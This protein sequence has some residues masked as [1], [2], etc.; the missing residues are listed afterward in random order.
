MIAFGFTFFRT[1]LRLYFIATVIAG[2]L[3]AQTLQLDPT[4]DGDGKL[5]VDFGV[6]GLR[7]SFASQLF[8]QPSGRIVVYGTHVMGGQS[9]TQGNAACGLTSGG[10]LDSGFGSGGRAV[11]LN[12][13]LLRR[14]E[15]LPN[16]QFLR[17]VFLNPSSSAGLTR[18]NSDGSIDSSFNADLN[19][20]QASPMIMTTRPD[21]KIIVM[22]QEFNINEQILLVRLNANGSRDMSFGVNGVSLLN[23]NRVRPFSP[24]RMYV[25][26]DNRIILG[27]YSSSSGGP[28][29][30]NIAWAALLDENGNLDRRFGLQGIF[31]LAFPY[32]IAVR[33]TLLQ[34]DGKLI[35]VGYVRPAKNGRL[36][37]IRLT[38]RGRRDPSFGDNGIAIAPNI[39]P[40]SYD[41]GHT[42]ELMAD[43]RILVAGSHAVTLFDRSDFLIARFSTSGQLE[44]HAITR[45]TPNFDT[46]A[47]DLLIQPDGKPVVAGFTRNPDVSADGNLFAVARYT[48]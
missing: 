13:T 29:G 1:W 6:A 22:L 26:P 45:F 17:L 3:T 8:A 33:D 43:G 19:I 10:A 35:L 4:F 39:S 20:G 28:Q 36:L 9:G 34:P 44:S 48:Q 21:G 5:T 11:Q 32:S 23:L 27:G 12:E 40:D 47:F 42:A 15:P 38:A 41:L 37:M 14:I 30:G 25:L 2:S 31:R 7:S 24:G 46:A 16:G 18:H